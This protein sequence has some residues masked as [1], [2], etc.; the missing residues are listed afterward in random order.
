[1]G[2]GW[3]NTPAWAGS[4]VMVP[5]CQQRILQ[6]A[7]RRVHAQSRTDLSEMSPAGPFP[8]AFPAGFGRGPLGRKH[9]GGFHLRVARGGTAKGVG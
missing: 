4:I 6:R 8:C 9:H 3:S 7:G 1:M 2:L 5:L